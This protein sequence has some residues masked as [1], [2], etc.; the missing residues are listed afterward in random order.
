MNLVFILPRKNKK[1]KLYKKRG[2]KFRWATNDFNSWP[3]TIGFS[4]SFIN[5][6]SN[7]KGNR[8]IQKRDIMSD[9]L[10]LFNFFKALEKQLDTLITL[11]CKICCAERERER[12]CK[13]ER[14]RERE[15]EGKQAK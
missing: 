6:K 1:K 13:R 10:R 7:F 12:E 5:F 4:S 14:E 11:Q 3:H 2:F 8:L 15:R 9:T